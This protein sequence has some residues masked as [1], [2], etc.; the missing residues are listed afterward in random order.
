M[1]HSGTITTHSIFSS[2][3]ERVSRVTVYC[4]YVLYIIDDSIPVSKDL[5]FLSIESFSSEII[6]LS[7]KTVLKLN[8]EITY[9]A[10][11]PDFQLDRIKS[12]IDSRLT[13]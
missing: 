9:F 11:A 6:N 4:I 12:L 7:D 10:D 1:K 13:Y 5:I 2:K 8:N 3:L